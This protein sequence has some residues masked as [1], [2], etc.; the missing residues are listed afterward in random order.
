MKKLLWV[1][2]PL[3]WFCSAASAQRWEFGL[4]RAFIHTS[5][6]PLGSFSVENKR[7]DDTK[8]RAKW[9][10]GGRITLNTPGYYG[11]ELGYWQ[12]RA[13]ITSLLRTTTNRVQ[14]TTMV[15]DQVT[16][17]QYSFNFLVYFMPA[18][19]KWRPFI[20]GGI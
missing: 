16:L 11:Y 5:R 1:T 7:D 20:T 15:A 4:N 14:T 3:L 13:D 17:R 9:A 10:T 18:N 12:A 8:L 2:L 19:E 6:K